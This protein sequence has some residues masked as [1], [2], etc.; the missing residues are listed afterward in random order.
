M[1][2]LSSNLGI[3][4]SGLQASQEA[5][6]VIGH[7][8]ANVNTPGYTQQAAVLNT[9]PSQ[10]FGNLMFGTGVT[11]SAVQSLRDQFLNLQVTQSISSQ[12][13]SE[14]L[15]NGV[16][17]VSPAFKDDGTTGLN[18]QISQFFTSLQTLAGNPENAAL[19]ENV[20]GMAQSMLAE[21]QSVRQTVGGQISSANNEIGS[22][23]PQINTI[24]A[25]IA[26]LN[27]QISN[28]VNP[29]GANDAIDQRQQLTD[30]LAKLVGIQV[31]TDSQN[32]YQITL[33][34]GAATLVSGSA[35]YQMKAAP[36]GA[37]NLL[38]VSVASGNTSIDV[39]GQINGGQLGG[40]L[41]L[42]DKIL[43]GYQAQVDQL[44]GSLADQVNTVATDG[45][46]TH[47][48]PHRHGSAL[49][50]SVYFNG[51]HGEA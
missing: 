25:Q 36:G 5:M 2:N 30:Q 51:F 45:I 33:D 10:N 8:I 15:Y 41:Q 18:T 3:G 17:A 37:G 21:F 24:T 20:V 42:R 48:S 39:T 22:L 9:N 47:D 13:G 16:S 14:T 26:S 44:A 1:A 28:L 12:S 43:P 6:S 7:N 32:N 46:A 38:Q 23:V 40:D 4:L 34:S 50:G 49:K 29:G 27:S 11:V 19:S 31:S 35:S